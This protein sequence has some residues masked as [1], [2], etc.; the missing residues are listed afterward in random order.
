V[1]G[2]TFR[3]KL[4]CGRMN[5]PWQVVFRIEWQCDKIFPSKYPC[6]GKTYSKQIGIGQVLYRPN[7]TV[8]GCSPDKLELCQDFLSVKPLTSFH[9]HCMLTNQHQNKLGCQRKL[10]NTAKKLT[11]TMTLFFFY[12][13]KEE[14]SDAVILPNVSRHP[15]VFNPLT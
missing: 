5:I 3:T 14:N 9:K 13:A 4:H 2:C 10:W 7:C 15:K 8:A 1:A 11:A 6:C 12:R